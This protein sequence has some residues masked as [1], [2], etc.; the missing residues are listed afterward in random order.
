[1][2]VAKH[3]HKSSVLSVNLPAELFDK[4]N[5]IAE[6]EERTKSYYVKKALEKFLAEKLEDM[7]DY[8]D[9]KK[10][11]EEFVAS[12]EQGTPWEEVKKKL[13]L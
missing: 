12:G 6:F 9:A 1:M 13:S 7:E 11:Y 4:L 3:D 2:Q 5:K 8:I 10:A